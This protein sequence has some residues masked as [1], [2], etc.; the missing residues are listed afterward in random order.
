MTVSTIHLVSLANWKVKRVPG[1]N[2]TYQDIAFLLELI[3]GS[4]IIKAKL[5]EMGNNEPDGDVYQEIK[6]LKLYGFCFI[7]Y[8]S[9][10][11]NLSC[12]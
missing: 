12:G 9:G 11:E 3:I 5:K 10:I 7:Y 8:H 4:P 6:C 2:A 1:T